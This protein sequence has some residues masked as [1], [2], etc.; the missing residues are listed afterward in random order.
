MSDIDK[1]HFEL[2]KI[3]GKSKLSM[4]NRNFEYLVMA[5]L[6]Q[7]AELRKN[8]QYIRYSILFFA[9]FVILGYIVSTRFAEDIPAV[10]ALSPQSL[11]LIF[12]AVFI[13]CILF[14]AEYLVKYYKSHK[15]D[16]S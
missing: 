15:L 16:I 2:G 8:R 12:Q 13:L 9:L 11:K 4:P 3:I 1:P 6:K 7:E 10:G 5:R 14:R